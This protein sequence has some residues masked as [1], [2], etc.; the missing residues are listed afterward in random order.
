MDGNSIP[1]SGHKMLFILSS[2][3]IVAIITII[4]ISSLWGKHVGCPTCSEAPHCP[5]D[6]EPE[7][8]HCNSNYISSELAL[9]QCNTNKLSSDNSLAQCNA[10]KLISDNSLTQCNTDKQT[11]QNTLNNY[12]SNDNTYQSKYNTCNTS[13]ITA[14]GKVKECGGKLS[15]CEDNTNSCNTNLSTANTN[16]AY[17][18]NL[19]G[20]YQEQMDIYNKNYNTCNSSYAECDA[21]RVAYSQKYVTAFNDWSNTKDED[22][23]NLSKCNKS[24]V[25]CEAEVSH[26]NCPICQTNL[27]NKYVLNTSETNCGGSMARGVIPASYKVNSAIGCLQECDS[28]PTC[29]YAVWTAGSLPTNCD[30]MGSVSGCIPGGSGAYYKKVTS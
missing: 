2:L 23:R 17:Y 27:L 24:L 19:A 25:T 9:A 13:L 10:N 21:D 6:Y 16:S 22:D 4:I 26:P 30:L 1:K 29:N 12:N 15:M 3:L 18:K 11:C 20:Q 8:D 28:Y 5:H 14:E 7:Y